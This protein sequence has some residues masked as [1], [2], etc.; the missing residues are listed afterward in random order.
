MDHCPKHDTGAGPCYCEEQSTEPSHVDIPLPH[1]LLL[2]VTALLYFATWI[3]VLLTID[4][5]MP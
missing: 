4:W 5:V 1:W 2:G 3:I